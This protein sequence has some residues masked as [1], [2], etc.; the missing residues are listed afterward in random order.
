MSQRSK[1]IISKEVL[2]TPLA[3]ARLNVNGF[4]G[5]N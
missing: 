1:A 5:R 4:S 2:T 3:T